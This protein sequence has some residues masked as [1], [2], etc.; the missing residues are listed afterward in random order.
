MRC[1]SAL[2]VEVWKK[3]FHLYIRPQLGVG[4]GTATVE[5]KKGKILNLPRR[6]LLYKNSIKLKCPK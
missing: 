4:L 5:K 2:I 1:I 6:S 3:K